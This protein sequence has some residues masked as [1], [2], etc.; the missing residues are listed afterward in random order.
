MVELRWCGAEGGGLG[1]NTVTR[2]LDGDSVL[3]LHPPLPLNPFTAHLH[4]AGYYFSK[5]MRRRHR[6]RPALPQIPPCTSSA[7]QIS[8]RPPADL[9]VDT[10]T[11]SAS[12]HVKILPP[13]SL[14]TVSVKGTPHTLFLNTATPL[15]AC[16]RFKLQQTG[17]T[18]KQETLR[19]EPVWDFFFFFLTSQ[20]SHKVL[21]LIPDPGR[22]HVDASLSKVAN[23]KLPSRASV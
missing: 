17:A 14:I 1:D 18:A 13:L 11:A 22:L 20:F 7:S 3:C 10:N 21:R 15:D 8:Q 19:G 5:E 2:L 16:Y 12:R 23:L 9:R 6:D 4:H